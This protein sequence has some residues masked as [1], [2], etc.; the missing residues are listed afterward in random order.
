MDRERHI[1]AEL[2][3]LPHDGHCTLHPRPMARQ[4][5]HRLHNIGVVGAVLGMVL[6]HRFAIDRRRDQHAIRGE[7]KARAQ[8]LAVDKMS[9]LDSVLA[10]DDRWHGDAISVD[11]L[12]AAV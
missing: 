6:R 11:R 2:H 4:G 9:H 10:L 3:R 7:I 8:N 1:L 5:L 12:E